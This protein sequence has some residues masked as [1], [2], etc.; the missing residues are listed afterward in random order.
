MHKKM[1]YFLLFLLFVLCLTGCGSTAEKSEE[2]EYKIYYSNLAG[3][4]LEEKSYHPTADKFDGLL[5]ELLDQYENPP[6]DDMK[7]AMPVGVEINGYSMG[8]DELQVDF[9]AAYLSISNIQ[10]VLLRASLVKTLVQLPGVLRLTITVDGQPL[11]DDDGRTV[12]AMNEDTF[13]DARGEGINSYH[14]ITLNLYFASAA[15]DKV[16]KEMRNV[17][18]SSN[19]IVEKVIVEQIIR[20]PVNENL[21]PVVD[22]S[23]KV[24]NVQIV[25]N[26][27]IIDLNSAFNTVPLEG[28]TDATASLYAF[29]NAICDACDVEGV[30][31]EIEGETDV[32]FRNEISLNQVFKRDADIIEASGLSE[33]LTEVFLD[34]NGAET[35]TNGAASVMQTEAA[36]EDTG[37]TVLTNLQPLTETRETDTEQTSDMEETDTEENT[38]SSLENETEGT[39]NASLGNSSGGNGIG[40]DPVLA[41]DHS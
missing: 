6:Y 13:I 7:C 32:R 14:Y 37:D 10:E 23:V 41:E 25:N 18:Y 16:V 27:C 36:L 22:T 2:K 1:I 28:K 3:S 21:L 30:Q 11:T 38:D 39:S 35:A 26:I 12:D 17:F 33:P 4:R 9:N 5:R 19:M 24:R 20:G 34:E 15:G 29:V 31:F 40:I 8:I